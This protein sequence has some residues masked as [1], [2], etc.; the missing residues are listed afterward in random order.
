MARVTASDAIQLPQA[1]EVEAAL[2]GACIIDPDALSMAQAADVSEGV[3]FLERHRLIW[4]AMV[5]IV[6]G[7]GRIADVVTLNAH[8][9]DRQNG[10]GTQLDAIG[11]PATIVGLITACPSSAPPYV[12]EWIGVLRAHQVRRALIAAGGDIVQMAHDGE[13]EPEA[14]YSRA[15]QRVMECVQTEDATSHLYGGP[16][17][18]EDYLVGQQ[19][20]AERLH[21]DP[22]GLV[23]VPWPTMGRMLGDLVPGTA[24]V[25]AAESSV[26]K[27]M[28]MEAIAEHNAQHGHR[29][30]Y[31]HLELSH[32]YMMHRAVARHAS[33]IVPIWKL[34]RG[35]AGPEVQRG[36]DAMSKW[37][38]RL[39][40]IFCAGW[41]VE[42][43]AADA[44][45]LRHR[46]GLDL[47]ILD[48]LQM[49]PPAQR[50]DMN[51]AQ[52]IGQQVAA[53]RVLGAQLDI[54]IVIGSQVNRA[55]KRDGR[56]PTEGDIR[57]SGEVNEKANQVVVL[58]RP[59]AREEHAGPTEPIE[60]WVDKNVGGPTGMVRL[61]HTLGRF[62]LVE[63]APEELQMPF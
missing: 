33:G 44:K 9:E 47:L 11:G 25:I 49:L 19:Q 45:R 57:N 22:G 3:F 40:Y 46:H 56:R 15:A 17:A 48:Y 62:A 51:Q 14:L 10:Q 4:R 50:R 61:L 5:E 28:A 37:I 16:E 27:T 21:D 36:I 23:T 7:R 31:Y 55:N 59:K 42:R 30:A 54:P 1:P 18:L 12:E 24:M 39:T 52:L 6:A 29:V 34:R 43:I 26:G 38:D 13:V 60:A 32:E 20:R 35:Y 8:L 58:H 63:A 53:L 41:S 2:L